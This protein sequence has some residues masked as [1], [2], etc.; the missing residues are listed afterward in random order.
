MGKLCVKHQ[1]ARSGTV[2]TAGQLITMTAPGGGAVNHT[3][4]GTGE[5]QRVGAG[6]TKCQYDGTGLN[7]QTDRANNKTYFTTLTD[8]GLLS[9]T[10]PSGLASAGTYYYLDDGVGNVGWNLEVDPSHASVYR[11]P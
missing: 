9:E 1:V 7:V 10:I 5:A 4:T 8:G 2:N 3:Y 11:S 6:S